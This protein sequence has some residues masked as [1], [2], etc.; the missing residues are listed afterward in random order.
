MGHQFYMPILKSKSGEFMALRYLRDDVKCKIVPLIEVT[1]IEYDSEEN[2][3][4]KTIEQH[5]DKFCTRVVKNWSK[6]PWFL[7]VDYIKNTRPNGISPIEYLYNK[8]S[9][10]NTCPALVLRINSSIDFLKSLKQ[11]NSIYPVK[12]IG[13][14]FL[15]E[16]LVDPDHKTKLDFILKELKFLPSNCHIII[17]LA[18]T[19]FDDLEGLTEAVLGALDF[20]PYLPDW[21]SITIASGAFPPTGSIDI[22]ACVIPRNDWKL[23]KT[24]INKLTTATI[25]QPNFGDYGVVA[26]GHFEF[27]PKRMTA[28]ANIRYTSKDNWLVIKGT[29]LKKKNGYLQYYE[30]ADAIVNSNHFLGAAFSPADM[31]LYKCAK[32][33]E[34][35]GNSPTWKWV[36]QNHHFFQVVADLSAIYPSF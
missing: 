8:F 21:K 36:G 30:Q 28:S 1:Q 35:P 7:D 19:Q 12:E 16:D 20:F 17:D 23:Y 33:E 32:K 9:K 25:K 3:K 2:K 18:R 6:M 24:L 15:I 31:Y 29:S 11:V 26:P 34:G 13:F 4:P 27:D 5:L 22:G 14:R 10:A